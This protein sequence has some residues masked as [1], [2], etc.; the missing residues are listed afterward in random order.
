LHHSDSEVSSAL[1]AIDVHELEDCG[2]DPS[3]LG[4]SPDIRFGGPSFAFDREDEVFKIIRVVAIAEL[5]N[6][7]NPRFVEGPGSPGFHESFDDLIRPQG[8]E[9]GGAPRS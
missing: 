4:S 9:G 7:G 3:G 6:R 8:L 2:V 1:R 5:F